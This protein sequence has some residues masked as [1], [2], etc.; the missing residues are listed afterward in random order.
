MCWKEDERANI[1]AFAPYTQIRVIANACAG[2]SPEAHQAA[3]KVMQSCQ[4]DIKTME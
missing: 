4:I 2:T 1:E 3:L